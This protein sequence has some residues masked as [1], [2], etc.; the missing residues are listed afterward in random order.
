MPR[1]LKWTPGLRRSRPEANGPAAGGAPPR[2]AET[3]AVGPE[4][5][6]G[7]VA[8][9][10]SEV[11]APRGSAVGAQGSSLGWEPTQ[12][13]APVQVSLPRA[14]G[15]STGTPVLRVRGET[16]GGGGRVRDRPRVCECECVHV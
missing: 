13:S 11:T 2:A 14:S 5:A 9:A 16:C 12:T 7:R 1:E 8:G 4:A 15:G 6:A 3:S 10:G